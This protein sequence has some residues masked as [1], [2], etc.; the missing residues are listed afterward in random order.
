[1]QADYEQYENLLEESQKISKD[2]ESKFGFS[3]GQFLGYSSTTRGGRGERI[4]K[5]L[6]NNPT[7]LT[8]INEFFETNNL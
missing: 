4:N 1:M 5:L 8:D 2:F 3:L 6:A 7:L